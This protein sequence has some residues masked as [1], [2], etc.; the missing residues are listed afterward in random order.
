MKPPRR[1]K[2]KQPWL[3]TFWVLFGMVISAPVNASGTANCSLS[4]TPLAFGQYVSASNFPLD[5]TAT[6]SVTCFTLDTTTHSIRGT[7]TPNGTS[8]SAGLWLTDRIHLL[9]YQLY[10]DPGRTIT[11][12][13]N[14]ENAI[15]VSGI[16]ERT[17]PF[18]RAFT[19]YGRVL[20]RQSN[21]IMGHYVDQITA[22]LNY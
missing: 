3:A 15:P 8:G 6:I 5:F 20:A 22:V 21:A 14:S 16:V 18:Q 11:W 13:R 19:L 12:E 2:P 10:V 9:R 17:I 1:M 7:I 4:A